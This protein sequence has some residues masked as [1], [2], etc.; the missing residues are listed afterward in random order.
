[1]K[2][3]L[4]AIGGMGI[5]LLVVLI[6]T[7]VFKIAPT[8]SFWLSEGDPGFG[9]SVEV[10]RVLNQTIPRKNF[11][12]RYYKQNSDPNLINSLYVQYADS[13]FSMS[14]TKK[15]ADPSTGGGEFALLG[16]ALCQDTTLKT[17]LGYKA[18]TF[19][20]TSTAFGIREYFENTWVCP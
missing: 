8:G 4:L 18:I 11:T 14:N 9:S 16:N 19:H 17:E 2:K 5:I 13:D 1:M 12:L 3:I 15:Y 10:K 6:I 20:V 7:G